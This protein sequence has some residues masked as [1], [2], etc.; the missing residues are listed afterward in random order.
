M[1]GALLLP[2]RFAC[3]TVA[4][5]RRQP[6][7]RWMTA[8]ATLAPQKGPFLDNYIHPQGVRLRF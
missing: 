8:P 4:G 6:P 3:A 7:S 5:G 1:A 2:R